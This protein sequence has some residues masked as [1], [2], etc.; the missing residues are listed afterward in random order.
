MLI[1]SDQQT[2][3]YNNGF[4]C[5]IDKHFIFL[6]QNKRKIG[7]ANT[8]K[9]GWDLHL[10]WLDMKHDDKKTVFTKSSFYNITIKR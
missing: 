5:N 6:V 8:N 10:N 9:H 4:W 1:C 3:A 7:L 2:K